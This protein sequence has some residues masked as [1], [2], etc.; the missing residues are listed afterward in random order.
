MLQR[1]LAKLIELITMIEEKMLI[2][3]KSI[4][5]YRKHFD[6]EKSNFFD[7]VKNEDQRIKKQKITVK[8]L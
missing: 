3:K 1:I 8:L 4:A 2:R 5:K 7:E 6:S